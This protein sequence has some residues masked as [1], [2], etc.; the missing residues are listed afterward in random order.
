M[1]QKDGYRA[2]ESFYMPSKNYR[3]VEYMPHPSFARESNRKRVLNVEN[4]LVEFQQRLSIAEARPMTP[5]P[6]GEAFKIDGF[7]DLTTAKIQEIESSAFRDAAGQPI[8]SLNF[9]YFVVTED[10]PSNRVPLS[11]LETEDSKSDRSRFSIMW[12]GTKWYSFGEFTGVKGDAGTP[13][14]PAEVVRMDG[15]IDAQGTRVG[16]LETSVVAAIGRLDGVDT[17]LARQK[18]I[19]DGLRSD[20]TAARAVADGA[21]TKSDANEAIVSG[22]GP[23]I[24]A[25]ENEIIA[26]KNTAGELSTRVQNDET[27]LTGHIAYQ[28]QY[29]SNKAAWISGIEVKANKAETDILWLTQQSSDTNAEVLKN[30]N[31]AALAQSTATS[32]GTV[33]A[34]NTG[35]IQALAGRASTVEYDVGVLKTKRD[36]QDIVNAETTRLI[37]VQ[38]DVSALL[39]TDLT[40]VQTKQGEHTSQLSEHTSQLSDIVADNLLQSGRL[41]ALD[42]QD[43]VHTEA[44]A[45][46]SGKTVSMIVVEGE[47]HSNNQVYFSSGSSAWI[48]GNFGIHF[49][50][51]GTI[52]FGSGISSDGPSADSDKPC[53]F[54]DIPITM[55]HPAGSNIFD[56]NSTTKMMSLYLKDNRL[57]GIDNISL[58]VAA[59]SYGGSVLSIGQPIVGGVLHLDTRFRLSFEFK[60]AEDALI[61]PTLPLLTSSY[62][63]HEA[64]K[65]TFYGHII[66]ENGII[67]YTPS[68]NG[69]VA[70]EVT[71]IVRDTFF[72]FPTLNTTQSPLQFEIAGIGVMNRYFNAFPHELV[73]RPDGTW[74]TIHGSFWFGDYELEPNRPERFREF[75]KMILAKDALGQLQTTITLPP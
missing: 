28:T 66:H 27:R 11:G 47:V 70:F 69:P 57:I 75:A 34:S 12:D 41:S 65:I 58:P 59:Q 68:S 72:N 44:L 43:S 64:D 10:V 48:E 18:T 14:D 49:P 71:V 45:A 26:I 16:A 5:G 30:K 31:A 54:M 3:L 73:L 37:G 21:K 19:D 56:E 25:N 67:K 55:Y 35:E 50:R 52:T 13:F 38:S 6:A 22:H 9:Y 24:T 39:R 17:E 42:A 60:P 7:G 46:I 23:R 29:D 1:N 8:T 51:A 32:A 61:L 40:A 53:Q 74:R 36:G 2:I 62:F 20:L 4:L 33:A 15:R 63:L